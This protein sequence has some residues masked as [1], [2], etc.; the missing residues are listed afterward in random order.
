MSDVPS[1][2]DL[3]CNLRSELEAL[4]YILIAIITLSSAYLLLMFV[5]AYHNAKRVAQIIADQ[6]ASGEGKV[7]DVIVI[8]NSNVDS[9]TT[10]HL[11]RQTSVASIYRTIN[12]VEMERFYD[13][14]PDSA[15][16][17][18]SLRIQM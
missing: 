10:T 18:D 15:K 5:I 12:S 1:T 8:E 7:P 4:S 16:P 2:G 9:N 11:G 17:S 14:V 13:K 6:E 3:D